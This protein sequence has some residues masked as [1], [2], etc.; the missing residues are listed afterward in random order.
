M[1]RKNLNALLSVA[2]GFLRFLNP[3]S[4]GLLGLQNLSKISGAIGGVNP[5]GASLEALAAPD[6]SHARTE[7]R[8]I[9]ACLLPAQ[10]TY[11]LLL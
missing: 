8:R 5:C 4:V 3:V 6:T 10:N 1:G 9:P 7:V 11:R 2:C